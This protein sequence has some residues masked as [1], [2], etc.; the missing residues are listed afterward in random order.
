MLHHPRATLVSARLR[1][2]ACAAVALPLLATAADVRA[3][4]PRDEAKALA[5]RA[6]VEFKLAHFEE[7]LRLYT[8]AYERFAAPALL[9][10]LGQCHKNLGHYDRAL[11][12]F[13]GY[14][15]DKPD[16]PNRVAVE[17]LMA[18]A[19][20]QLAE[21]RAAHASTDVERQ[22][23]AELEAERLAAEARARA[24]EELARQAAAGESSAG[25]FAGRRRQPALLVAGAVGGGVGLVLLGTGAYFGAHASSEATQLSQLS[26]GATWNAHEQS[27]YSNGQSSAHVATGLFVAGGVLAAA[28]VTVAVLGWGKPADRASVTVGVGAQP[29]G[30]SLLLA[31]R[32]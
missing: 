28:G 7:A 12:F 9:F 22:K 31:G 27:L 18:E 15:R 17:T 4:D 13:Q 24:A 14:L 3:A 10:N 2:L 30:S 32:F 23:I 26:S 6:A 16:A 1:L 21:E 5:S 20:R 19:T 29:G 25:W 11:F 8:Q